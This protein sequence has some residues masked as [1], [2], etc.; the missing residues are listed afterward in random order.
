MA[1][2]VSPVAADAKSKGPGR[3]SPGARGGSPGAMDPIRDLLDSPDAVIAVVGAT[4]HPD[5]FGSIIYRD[6]KANGYRVRAVNPYRSTV[7]GDPC[8]HTLRDLP[9][10]P[11]IVD[12]VVPPARTLRVLEECAALGYRTVW[13]Q[14]GAADDAV[15]VFAAAAG[16]DAIIDA[17]IM[18]DAKGRPPQA[19]PGGRP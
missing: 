13:I 7:D 14:P 8:W 17:C 5:K 18:V 4:D 10:A 9:E 12:L 3:E 19:P 6:L 11:T 2:T 1:D 15:R 16:L